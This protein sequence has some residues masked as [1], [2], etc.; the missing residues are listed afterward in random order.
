MANNGDDD[1]EVSAASV[2]MPYSMLIGRDR[3]TDTDIE[4][5]TISSAIIEPADTFAQSIIWCYSK[6]G[7]PIERYLL[8]II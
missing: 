8:V 6:R 5:R 7:M 2:M 3:D 4:S 1:D